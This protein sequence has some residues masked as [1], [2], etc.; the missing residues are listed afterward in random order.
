MK[1]ASIKFHI[2]DSPELDATFSYAYTGYNRVGHLIGIYRKL[3]TTDGKT[4]GKALPHT[5]DILRAAVVLC[6]ANLEQVLR[7][8]LALEAEWRPEFLQRIPLPGA[9]HIRAD[10]FSLADLQAF[11]DRPVSEVVFEAV[12][13]SLSKRSFTAV[14]DV[15]EVLELCRQDVSDYRKFFP[16]IQA[17]MERRHHIAHTADL[18]EDPGR[19]KQIARSISARTVTRWNR[20]AFEFI[21]QLSLMNLPP[22]PDCRTSKRCPQI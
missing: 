21:V 22:R 6:H 9:K 5:S 7:D 17:L 11:G 16:G 3:R 20:N 19:G 10:R 2:P 14:S 18:E 4:R 1:P 15:V 8:L 12:W 13:E